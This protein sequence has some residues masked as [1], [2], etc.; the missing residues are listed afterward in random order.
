MSISAGNY[1]GSMAAYDVKFYFLDLHVTNMAAK[2]EGRVGVYVKL[3][4]ITDSL[5][6][7]LVDEACVDSIHLNKNIVPFIHSNDYIRIKLADT[8]AP[9]DLL[10]ID[11]FYSLTDASAPN[12]RG[13][14][15]RKLPDGKSLTWSL[16]EPFYSKNWFPCKQVLSDKADSAYMFF[17]A[18]D[19]L[20]VGSNG[21]LRDIVPLDSNQVRFE[22]VTKYPL[23]F[24]LPSFAVADYFD[25]SFKAKIEGYDSVL[26]QNYIP[27][28][29]SFLAKNR[30]DINTT[31]PLITLFSEK[32]GPYPFR[33]EKYG[34]CIAPIGG[35]MEH[36]TMT[37]LEN[38]DF[39]L[40]AHEL[41]HQWF[42]DYMTCSNWQDI[43]INEGFASY[44]EF[45]AVESI[46][47]ADEKKEWL[48]DAFSLSMSE[49]DGSVHVPDQDS[50]NDD[51]I[52]DYRLTYRK[53]AYIIHMI[54]HELQNDS[55]FFLVLKTSLQR[56]ANS[57]VTAENFKSILEEISQQS[58]E[59]FFNQWY[60]GEGYPILSIKWT[61]VNDSLKIFLDQQV[62]CPSRTPFFEFPIDFR[63]FYLNGDTSITLRQSIPE[64]VCA[65]PFDKRIYKISPDPDNWILKEIRSVERILENDSVRFSVF[66]NP[67][68]DIFY[69]ENIDFGLP[70]TARI[71]DSNGI[72]LYEEESAE[73]FLQIPISTLTKGVYQVVITREKHKEIFKLARL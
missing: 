58:F 61:Q 65:I 11:V 69:V 62:S 17:T 67:A 70:F 71:F 21:V 73:A 49:P 38:F 3:L 44:A 57:T 66:P 46:K 43:W 59:T 16:S 47:S 18:A 53:G 7:E 25:Y 50:V 51:R 52:F 30:A 60:F 9:G 31:A 13:I 6:L 22:W 68:S 24:Y 63:V 37:T 40:V 28:D 26:V 35:G 10:D 56:Y 1:T 33:N 8:L 32:F 36:Q 72:Q 12:D 2:I 29:S 45:I 39:I 27:D 54:R 15:T 4:S 48:N 20:L 42:G 34:H 19:S 64:M 41:A 55:L 14:S 5:V 23:A